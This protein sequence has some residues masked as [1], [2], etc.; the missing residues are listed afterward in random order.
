MNKDRAEEI[1]KNAQEADML[2]P[3]L[4][5]LRKAM[6]VA[7]TPEVYLAGVHV[8][9]IIDVPEAVTGDGT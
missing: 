6:L 7:D 1:I 8:R 3:P 5:L 9:L 4:R 2:P